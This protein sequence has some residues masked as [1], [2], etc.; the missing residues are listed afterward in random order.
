MLL[1]LALGLSV[2]LFTYEP[3]VDMLFPAFLLISGVAMELFLEHR[4]EHVDTAFTEP[5]S[6]KRML[7]YTAV[8]MLG[9]ILVS[10]VIKEEF[11]LTV[12]PFGFI[13]Y[14]VFI[15]IAEEQ[16]FRGFIT[17]YLLNSLPDPIFALI[18]SALI[19]LVYHL[20]R[21]G[22]SLDSLMYVFAGGF[23]LS[24]V[25]WKSQRISPSMNAHGLNNFYKAIM[26]IRS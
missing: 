4:R 1:I 15:G 11:P 10:G 16:F 24:Y 23:I 2:Y 9:L 26:V 6:L 25:A 21:Y 12:T 14:G 13:A 3:T 18:A 8:A 17:D 19:F 7:F 20:A 22:T 5:T